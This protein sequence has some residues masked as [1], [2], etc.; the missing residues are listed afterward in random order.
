[1]ISGLAPGLF[2]AGIFVINGLLL[3]VIG[4]HPSEDAVDTL[5]IC[6]HDEAEGRGKRSEQT[7]YR[8]FLPVSGFRDQNQTEYNSF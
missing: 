7:R 2:I 1:M 3:F 8:P 6:L 4:R 5:R